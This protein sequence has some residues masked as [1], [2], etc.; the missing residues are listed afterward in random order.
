MLYPAR[1]G[2]A[3]VP[4]QK[5]CIAAAA[6][7]LNSDPGL[8]WL[9]LGRT[10]LRLTWSLANLIVI[11]PVVVIGTHRG[12]EGVALALAARSLVATVVAQIITRR[13]AGVSHLGYLRAL[14]PGV[15]LGAAFVLPF[16]L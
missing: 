13:V 9:A 8:V 10:R 14:L 5:L 6:A 15:L 12:I 4:M 3:V 16:L 2:A 7:G 11:V 1:W